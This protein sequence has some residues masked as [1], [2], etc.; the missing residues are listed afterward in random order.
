METFAFTATNVAK[1]DEVESI[2]G[3]NNA[4]GQY[5]STTGNRSLYFD[6][7]HTG[8]FH[9]FWFSALNT[10]YLTFDDH[11]SESTNLANFDNALSPGDIDNGENDD[12]S[13]RVN[14]REF[15]RGFAFVLRD[16]NGTTGEYIRLYD[17]SGQLVGQVAVGSQPVNAFLGVI[18]DEPFIEIR[19]DEDSGGDDIAVTDLRFVRASDVENV[20][21]ED[22]IKALAATNVAA[23][24]T[25]IA[26]SPPIST[27]ASLADIA[28]NIALKYKP[29]ALKA[30]DDVAYRPNSADK[31]YYE[32]NLPQDGHLYTNLFGLV[33]TGKIPESWGAF[34]APRVSHA[35]TEVLVGALNE[36]IP[37]QPNYGGQ[38][39]IDKLFPEEGLP[40]SMPAGNN[41]IRWEATSFY[42][43]VFDLA[44]PMALL[45]VDLSTKPKAATKVAADA[46]NTSLARKAWK[47]FKGFFIAIGKKM[48]VAFKK[49]VSDTTQCAK[50]AVTQLA[51]VGKD[52]AKTYLADGLLG[53]EEATVTTSRT[54]IFT[55]YDEVPPTLSINVGELEFEATDIGGT[56]T[57]RILEQISATVTAIDGC[58]RTVSLTNDMPR[59][60]PLGETTVTWTARDKGPKDAS[61]APNE[62]QD[63]QLIRIVDTQ[64]PIMVPPAGKVIEV[65]PTGP[66]ASGLAE[67]DVSLGIPKV[68]DLADPLPKVFSDAPAFF[69]VNSRTPVTWS[70][71]DSSDN[72]S[73]GKQLITIKQLGTN[74]APV[75][76]NKQATTLTSEPVDI[77]L[78]GSDSDLLQ[79]T[80]T[81]ELVFDPLSIAILERPANGDFVAPLMPYFI[82]DFRTSPAGPFGEE[83][84]NASPQGIWLGVNICDN[85]DYNHLDMF[86]KIRRDWP[87]KPKFIDVA[88]DGTYFLIDYYWKCASGGHDAS[89]HP[90]ISKWS[91]NNEFLGQ[92]DYGGTSDTFVADP[93][94]Y[95]YVI[96]RNSSDQ[97]IT[98]FQKRAD[99]ENASGGQTFNVNLWK[100]KSGDTANSYS[101]ES[102]YLDN[103]NLIY[104]RIDTKNHLLYVTDRR[105]VFVFDVRK[106]FD[107]IEEPPESMYYRFIGA[108]HN[109]EQFLCLRNN[110]SS[111]WTGFA[112]EVD[113]EG[114]LYIA[115]SCDNRI[116][117]FEPSYFDDEGDFVMGEHI[118]WLGRCETSTND[119]CDEINQRSRGYACTDDTCQVSDTY[120]NENGLNVDGSFG[121]EAGQFSNPVYIDLNPNDVLYVA[122]AGRVQRFAKDGTFG[123]QAKST[124]TGINQGENPGF[125]LGNMGTV[126]AVT[127]NARNFFVVD[128][129]E[130]FIHVF[131]TTPLK[132]ITSNSATVTY[133][134]NFNFHSGIDTF[135]YQATDGLADSNTGTVSVQVNR[136]FRPPEAFAQ[137]LSMDEDTVLP[138]TLTADDPDGVI[139][140]DDVYPLDILTYH[141]V[142]STQHGSLTKDGTWENPVYTPAP[143]FY[144]RDSFTFRVHDGNEYSP[145]VT[146]DIIVNPVDDPPAIETVTLPDRIG[147]G[148]AFLHEAIF[149]DDTAS[150]HE[151]S[152]DWGNNEPTEYTG[153]IVDPG[154]GN[155]PYIDGVAIMQPPLGA[156]SGKTLAEHIYSDTGSK[157]VKLCLADQQERE[158]CTSTI[159]NIGDYANLSIDISS[160][161]D[162]I[163]ASPV[164]ITL[165]LTNELP[166]GWDGLSAN[167]VSLQQQS[168]ELLETTGFTLKPS[169]CSINS[170]VVTCTPGTLN[171]DASITLKFNVRAK[172]PVLYDTDTLLSFK[173]TTSTP[174]LLDEYIGAIALRVLANPTDT[175]G[176][177]MTDSFEDTYGLNKNDPSDWSGNNDGDKLNNLEEFTYHTH[178][179]KKDT[180]SDGLADD[181]EL[182]I[183][184]NPNL[185]DSDG[186]KL[187]D[188]WEYNNGLDPFDDSDA[189]QDPDKD[190]LNNLKEYQSGGKPLDNDTDNDNVSDGTDNCVITPNSDQKDF[191][192]DNKGDV[193]DDDDDND[194]MP[195]SFEEEHGLNPFNAGDASI[196]SDGDEISNLEEFLGGSNPKDPEDFPIRSKAWRAIIPLIL[197][198]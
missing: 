52:K 45:P 182:K 153:G 63:T 94:G 197:N 74:T 174:S 108:M 60:L 22:K 24:A 19:Y 181:V 166:E 32:F 132:D 157:T 30:P 185:A 68:V 46:G 87:H 112:M 73:T 77:V 184:T 163:D 167:N 37:G 20:N 160:S 164:E 114:Y 133:V 137:Q 121:K 50:E 15:L 95:L 67:A 122:D 35:N 1:A 103:Q 140:S 51:I 10:P 139:G 65:D 43:P 5:D 176:D 80:D 7:K 72:E 107:D 29:A 88:D 155:S 151:A 141:I 62:L 17:H 120:V 144:G 195:D 159:I 47:K 96:S 109:S 162:E 170:G 28:S 130:S 115:D 93:D 190:G 92:L 41:V 90:R 8:L 158:D 175:D 165:T 59:L 173:A 70:A 100:V 116:H 23:V 143:D 49:C 99:L 119:A 134:S 16:N 58:G 177:G 194:G 192:N 104:G 39:L 44:L 14:G 117:K 189:K 102:V 66:N 79:R 85:P 110:W 12:W 118:G 27:G 169:S 86:Q 89:T 135:T 179:G 149:H 161:L 168:S 180:D 2:P 78:T 71:K 4:V 13:V 91:S 196:D 145:P 34:G 152:I 106:E 193:C 131:E 76:T 97:S 111:S 57:G 123:G 42:D 6:R 98:I 150:D 191:D 25:G 84:I 55:V 186:D 156:G 64:A 26:T 127:V 172:K 38:V 53:S 178:P 3:A 125:I 48:N 36:H 54:Q 33:E 61:L 105:R 69:P 31:C 138:I 171:N 183:G 124:G 154:N 147:R 187:P 128:Q 129:A 146:I 18:S 75:V 11:E 126:K 40:V 188:G 56:S 136:N 148:F 142:Q 113:S 81:N 83:F 82:E 198:Q 21:L 101:G 9:S